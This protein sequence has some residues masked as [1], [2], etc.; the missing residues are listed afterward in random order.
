M[1]TQPDIPRPRPATL[2]SAER[3]GSLAHLT[4]TQQ[5]IIWAYF[6]L[7]PTIIG[8]AAFT[9]GPALASLVLAFFATNFITQMEMVGLSNFLE[10]LTDDVFWI[11]LGNTLVYVVGHIAPTVVLAL[12]LAIVLNQ[13]IRGR[14]IFRTI[15]FL[16]V[17]AP[18]V[19]TSLV[20]AWAY[21]TEF[22]VFNFFLKSLGLPAA[23]WL[24]SSSWAMLS[25]IIWS[26]WASIGYPIII[27]LAALQN[28]PR[29]QIEASKLDGAGAWQTFRYV[30]F[31]AISPTTFFIVVL[32]FIGAFQ[33]FTQMYVM[34][35]GGP[36][37]ATYTIVMYLYYRAWDSFR[38]GYASAVAVMLFI[39]LALVTLVQFRLQKE[40][41]YYEHD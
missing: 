26:V 41:V 9:L 25:V 21:Q 4:Y 24:T 8:L 3:T 35:Q 30:T 23:P 22:G 15:Y 37:Y 31:P 12:A 20:W 34:T 40:W 13:P 11:S 38:F 7:A 16:P 29:E 27:Y 32:Q 1:A 36:G 33:V 5:E 18:V 2:A 17:V 19:S 28:V 6:F 14:S 10:L 39:I